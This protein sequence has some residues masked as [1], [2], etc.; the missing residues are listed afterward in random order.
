[1]YHCLIGQALWMKGE[2]ESRRSDNSYGLL[3]WQMNENWPTGGWGCIE[4]GPPD[5]N[6]T[7]VVG[8]RWKPLMHLLES[9]LFRHVM[10]ACGTDN[11]CYVRNDG[12]ETLTAQISFETWKIGNAKPTQTLSYSII[13]QADAICK[14]HI[15]A[16]VNS[17]RSCFT[18][19][20][21]CQIAFHS[22]RN[23]RMEVAQFW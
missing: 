5:K 8:G 18:N 15:V 10:A 7:Q 3:I 19:L 21:P 6:H 14:Q 22:P 11:R 20:C 23:S 4:Y 2:I 12:R 16:I 9:H 1:M 17:E 13:L